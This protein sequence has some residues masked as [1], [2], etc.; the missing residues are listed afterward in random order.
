[1][2][3]RPRR[4]GSRAAGSGVVNTD[5]AVELAK[6]PA[7]EYNVSVDVY[8]H[9]VFIKIDDG[10]KWAAVSMSLEEAA[11]LATTLTVAAMEAGL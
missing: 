7:V 6:Q 9:R 11:S 2:S 4:Q 1:M 8:Q 5:Y 10:N 3:R